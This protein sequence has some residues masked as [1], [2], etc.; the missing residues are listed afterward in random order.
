MYD[1]LLYFVAGFF[2]PFLIHVKN[3]FAPV[4]KSSDYFN[5]QQFP[6]T[7]QLR[8]ILLK[9]TNNFILCRSAV[10]LGFRAL[11]A[12]NDNN[13]WQH[14]EGIAKVFFLRVL[15]MVIIKMFLSR[16]SSFSLPKAKSTGF[17][18]MFNVFFGF[19][20]THNCFA[21][22]F[23]AW[24]TSICCCAL[25]PMWA[26]NNWMGFNSNSLDGLEAGRC[27]WMLKFSNVETLS[28]QERVIIKALNS[29][30]FVNL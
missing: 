2:P 11:K 8:L 20:A 27:W 21:F 14:L 26:W 6:N 17:L 10:S 22:H 28:L 13:E 12:R 24:L 29:S 15:N 9:M 16:N 4:E 19:S 1:K 30:L 7:K 18:G 25:Y 3:C 23:Y 5:F